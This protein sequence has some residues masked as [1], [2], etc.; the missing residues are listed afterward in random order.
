MITLTC[1][2]GQ[3]N[4]ASGSIEHVNSPFQ[5][6]TVFCYK[7]KSSCEKIHYFSWPWYYVTCW[8]WGQLNCKGKMAH[9]RNPIWFFCRRELELWEKMA[10]S[11]P[12]MFFI[13]GEK[14][15]LELKRDYPFKSLCKQPVWSERLAPFSKGLSGGVSSQEKACISFPWGGNLFPFLQGVARGF[16]DLLR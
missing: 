9:F 7:K 4:G 11:R 10:L 3:G 14:M 12:N 16:H 5:C 2:R 6:Y 15:D 8:G 1:G 13:T